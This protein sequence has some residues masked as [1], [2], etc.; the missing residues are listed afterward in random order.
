MDVADPPET[1]D[2]ARYCR[3]GRA[4]LEDLTAAGC[5]PWWWAAPA[6]ISRRCSTA[7]SRR[8]NRPRRS[9]SG[10]V[11]NWRHLGLAVLYRRLTALDPATAARLHPHDT[12]RIVRALE[13]MEATGRPLSELIAAH[14]FQDA[15]IGC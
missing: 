7:C 2:A 12:Y 10:C 4:V 5:R 14:R 15:P 11:G 13:V 9:G 3:E 8:A 6:S 1:Y